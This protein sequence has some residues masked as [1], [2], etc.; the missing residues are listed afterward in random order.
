MSK[1]IF[2]KALKGHKVEKGCLLA[3]FGAC[4]ISTE[5]QSLLLHSFESV[6]VWLETLQLHQMLE[7]QCLV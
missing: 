4:C 7:K 6:Y 5:R 1:T 3:V 2:P